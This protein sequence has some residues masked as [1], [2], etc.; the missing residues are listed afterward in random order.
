MKKVVALPV[1]AMK[2]DVRL[3][4]LKS[5]VAVKWERSGPGADV[6]VTYVR[7]A[8]RRAYFTNKPASGEIAGIQTFSLQLNSV[9]VAYLASRIWL[10][11]PTQEAGDPRDRLM[12]FWYGEPEPHS[13]DQ[14]SILRELNSLKSMS[15]GYHSKF[16]AC[17]PDYQL[18]IGV[19][20]NET[21]GGEKFNSS[22]DM[23]KPRQMAKKRSAAANAIREALSDLR[24]LDSLF[25]SNE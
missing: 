18:E 11:N 9:Q 23:V 20:P 3:E 22:V 14:M 25:P 2:A 4:L 5:L 19:F 7:Q 10:V 12:E 13:E 16:T 8:D 1:S 24:F 17:C 21:F 15:P 6:M